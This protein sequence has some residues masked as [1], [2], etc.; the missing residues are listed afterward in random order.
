MRTSFKIIPVLFFA[1]GYSAVTAVAEGFPGDSVDTYQ[2]SVKLHAPVQKLSSPAMGYGLKGVTQTKSTNYKRWTGIKYSGYIRSYTQFRHMPVG[3]YGPKDLITQNGLDI[4][5]GGYNGYNEPLFLVRMEGAP[6]SKSFFKLEYAFDNQMAGR[7]FENTLTAGTGPN[8]TTSKRASAYR[9]LQFQAG[10]ST[11]L[12]EF[13]LTAGGGVLWQ[14]FSQFTLWQYQY[15]DDMFE[16][17]PW[18]P[19]GSA[20]GNRYSRYYGGGTIPR[21]AR[22][23]NAGTQGFIIEGKNLPKGFEGG[24][25]YGKT[26][27]SGGFQTFLTRSP[28]NAL[29]GKLGRAFGRKK[30]FLNYF[31]QFGFQ[32]PQARYRIKQQIVTV[33]G[34]FNY[35]K[36][37]INTEVGMG[38]FM[39]YIVVND[40]HYEKG[41]I[42]PGG[43][44]Y[45][46]KNPWKSR[47]INLTLDMGK[48]NAQLYSISKTV[49]NVNSEVLNSA[50]NH[51]LGSVATIGTTNDITTFAGV[52]TD[53]GQMTNNR[54][55]LNLKYE[56]NEKKF[57][58][59]IATGIGQEIE[60]LGKN[61]P[62][63]N[64]VTVQHRANAFTRSRFGYYTNSLGPYGRVINIF[65]RSFE[66]IMI[67]DINPGYKKS[68]NNL[69]LNLKY[70]STFLKKE[71]IFIN[72]INANTVQV[73]LVP[74]FSNS[75]FVRTFYEEFTTFFSL[76][77]KVSLVAFVSI[78][79]N[80]GNTRTVL[81]PENGK[82]I[83]MTDQ[84]YG[85]GF[86]YDIN[87]R[88]GFYVRN[89]WFNH[90]DK[91]FALDKFRG[92][93]S[94][95][96]LKI[97]F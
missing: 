69:D 72:Y 20:W 96:E 14:R 51:A 60:N 87:G 38:R 50:N 74:K 81:S 22:W 76:H 44:N 21:D 53:V 59:L 46:W 6:T 39:D 31:S 48:F 79:R 5:N 71:I 19:E 68:F 12:G 83:N 52:I 86:D 2:P 28:K 34:T 90:S 18:E 26:D 13:K 77:P 93:E 36:F 25:L 16:R 40:A 1:F 17:Y 75:A 42:A 29:A 4:Y 43:V 41:S 85:L 73:G 94:S 49:V 24:L 61:D 70:K 97:F 37:K 88:T 27:N 23:G 55:A 3:Y 92:F 11:K 95:A 10:A 56:N 30:F 62:F 15:R 58:Y 35:D 63:F 80:I 32:E 78:E 64:A 7:L 54:Q 9:I 66:K 91:N 57:K 33:E 89:R 45:N 47:C 65:R 67:T 84:G 8:A 82:P